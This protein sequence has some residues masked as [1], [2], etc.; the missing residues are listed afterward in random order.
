MPRPRLAPASGRA[1][2][3]RASLA[4]ALILPVALAPALASATDLE[5]HVRDAAGLPIPGAMV[6]ARSG[7][8][9]HER[10][11][12]SDDAGAY[13]LPDLPAATDVR[14][15]VRR[16]GWTDL[17]VDPLRTASGT[18][19]PRDFVLQRENDPAELAAQL[20]ANHWYAL[21][22]A[23][24]DDARD[25]EQ[26][27]RQCTYCHQQGSLQTRVRRS[28]EEWQKV[29]ALM[30]RMGGT[31]D[32][33]LRARIPELMTAAYDPA[34]AVPALTA[35]MHERDFV[36]PPSADAR[37]AIVDEWE[38]GGRASMQHDLAVHPDGRVYSVDM[39]Q[40]RLFRLDPGVPGGKRESFPIPD[41]GLPLGGDFG[42]ASVL[43]PNANAHVGPHSLQVAPDGGVWVTLALGNRLARFDPASASWRLVALPDGYY[44]HTLRFDAK[45]RIWYSIAVS[46]H[47]GMFDP[48]SG[49]QRVIRLPA[50]SVAESIGL[51]L[52]P[53]LLWLARHV[54]TERLSS[55]A[56]GDSLPV[57]YGVDVA[58][59]GSVW[60]SQLNAHRIGRVDPDTFA[61]EMI[62]VPFTGPRRL[63]FDSKGNLWIP[64]FSSS[65]VARFDPKSRV[66]EPIE[67][68]IEPAG[69]ETPYALNVDR[70]TDTVWICGTE[71]D[72]L[73]RLEPETRRF[74]VYPLPTR[75]TYTREID[76]DA[77][78]RPWTSN[79]NLPAWQIETGV[80]RVLRLDPS[81]RSGA[82]LAAR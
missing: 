32:A 27:K 74:T 42:S 58:P 50:R 12:F 49:D 3:A 64:G 44:P 15:R 4:L 55:N 30:A 79:S 68:P 73:I 80:P 47:L 7:D 61:L 66:F 11:V 81:P 36:P 76:F 60:L 40:D 21:L 28:P 14:V 46:N 1:G 52:L 16:I 43:P 65:L 29:L 41:A 5:G 6:T 77:E 67:L 45:G 57:P 13:R 26:L 22:L 2:V 39:M 48:A 54:D 25:R 63:R 24:L 56:E 59:D 51:R 20:P 72:T 71:S 17:V 9:L 33:D 70:R 37:R 18:D 34:T 19:T 31:L 75:V 78:G 82:S 35:R 62:D 38:L 53:A 8:P 23:R 69:T 10:T